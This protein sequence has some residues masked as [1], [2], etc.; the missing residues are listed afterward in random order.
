V[1][2]QVHQLGE[3]PFACARAEVGAAAG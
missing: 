1:S 3:A 2:T